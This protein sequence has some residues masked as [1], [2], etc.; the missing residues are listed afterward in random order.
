MDDQEIKKRQKTDVGA[1]YPLNTFTRGRAPQKAEAAEE[2]DILLASL[3][4]NDP[5]PHVEN[6]GKALIRLVDHLRL[7][8]KKVDEPRAQA[9][10]ETS[11][12]ILQ[13]L[14][15]SFRDYQASMRED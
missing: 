2:G 3:T 4:T 5:L 7:D 1:L 8:L 14:A 15:E 13:G 6:I 11:A 10:F 9:L 12:E